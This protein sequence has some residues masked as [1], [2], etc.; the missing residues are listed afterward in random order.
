[1]RRVQSI[2]EFL[3]LLKATVEALTMGQSLFA[4]DECRGA[5]KEGAIFFT[6]DDSG[7]AVEGAIFS[8]FC[9]RRW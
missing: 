9:R 1:M 6:E 3:C 8:F 4:E 5:V 7:G 2:I